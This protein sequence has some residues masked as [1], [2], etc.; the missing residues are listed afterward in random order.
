MLE[1]PAVDTYPRFF[2]ELK[3]QIQTAQ[4]RASLAVNREL[5]LLYWQIGRDILDRQERDMGRES[6]RPPVHGPQASVSRYERLLT[7]Q[8]EIHAGVRRGLAR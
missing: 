1:L 6:D 8:S 3:K 7:A 2:A 5:V 4:L